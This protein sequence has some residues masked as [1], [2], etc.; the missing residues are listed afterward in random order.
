MTDPKAYTEMTEYVDRVYLQSVE[1]DLIEE[2]VE[3]FPTLSRAT[4][5]T[6]IQVQAFAKFRSCWSF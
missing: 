6:Y 2:C 4:I 3:K 1:K 5:E